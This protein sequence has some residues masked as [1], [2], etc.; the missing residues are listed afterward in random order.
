MERRTSLNSRILADLGPRI[1]PPNRASPPPYTPRRPA[2]LNL[3]AQEP[4]LLQPSPT[5]S[6]FSTFSEASSASAASAASAATAATTT[7]MSSTS[8]TSTFASAASTPTTPTF[9]PA[10]QTVYA[11]LGPGNRALTVRINAGT[12]IHGHSN[13]VV[14]RNIDALEIARAVVAAIRQYDAQVRMSETQ[15]QAQSQTQ[16]QPAHTTTPPQAEHR[17]NDRSIVVELN[18][19]VSVAGNQ[20]IVGQGAPAAAA[21]AK[22]MALR[23]VGRMREIAALKTSVAV[24]FGVGAETGGEVSGNGSGS[25]SR[26]SGGLGGDG[27]GSGSGM[28]GAA[29]MRMRGRRAVSA[30]MARGGNGNGIGIARIGGLKRKAEDLDEQQEEIGARRI[31]RE[32]IEVKVEDV[33]EGATESFTGRGGSDAGSGA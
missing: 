11:P 8:A 22:K 25:V 5:S 19:P 17:H 6:T 14:P 29:R 20:N 16:T 24:G 15:A 7:S 31:K 10:L 32:K 21:L 23:A 13:L 1:A 9:T 27:N 28:R 2:P 18:T 12:T 33:E 26:D 4:A 30:G 3:Q